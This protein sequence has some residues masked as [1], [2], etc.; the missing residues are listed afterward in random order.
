[1]KKIYLHIGAGKTGTSAI[2]AQ[3]AINK[4][5]MSKNN[6]YYPTSN[7][8]E[9]AKNFKITSGNAVQLALVMKEETADRNKIEKIVKDYVTEAKGKDILLSSE[10]MQQYTDEAALILKEAALKLG[11]EVKL[12]YYVRAIADHMMSSYHQSIKRHNNTN[13][14]SQMIRGKNKRFLQT[15]E[16]SGENFGFENL[17]LKNY[18]MVKDN[19]FV[20]FLVNV[21]G[22]T[23]VSEF[24]IVNK[25]VNRSLT[26]FELG[27][28]K[29]MNQFFNKNGQS[30]FVSDALIHNNPNMK[31]KMTIS[32]KD[33][34][35]L[36]QIHEEE[37]EKINAYLP[38]NERPLK[39]VDSLNIVDDEKTIELNAFQESVSAILAEII[40]EVKKK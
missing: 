7:T 2:Q 9:R 39:L 37:L 30:A 11:Y 29:H 6:V 13:D 3:L 32:Q 26:K 4:D 36:M 33:V 40:K 31:Y 16:R 23:D 10:T 35:K 20:D 21:L 28:M 27:L 5:V 15:I 18:D 8:E 19:I 25:T 1:M 14:F 22:I 34:D 38:E 12:V 17:V 24:K